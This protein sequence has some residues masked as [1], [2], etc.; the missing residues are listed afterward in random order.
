M[1]Y[2]SKCGQA[3]LEGDKFCPTCGNCVETQAQMPPQQPQMPPQQPVIPQQPQMPPQQPYA[4]QQAYGYGGA[5]RSSG[6]V[7]QVLSRILMGVLPVALGGGGYGLYHYLNNKQSDT[8][9]TTT[10]TTTADPTQTATTGDKDI[11]M[12]DAKAEPAALADADDT[13]Y[14]A[15]EVQPQYGSGSDDLKSYLNEHIVTSGSEE[16]RV[17][18]QF[19]VEKDGSLSDISVMR[20]VNETIDAEVVRVIS[21][22]PKWTPGHLQGKVVRVKFTLP[23]TVNV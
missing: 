20:G 11:Q 8:T 9:T 6:T 4:P 17:I 14:D 19:V 18:V 2:C 5:P 15:V 16:K 1:P 23:V 13:V 21:A 10:T 7:K 22:M 12:N 3:L